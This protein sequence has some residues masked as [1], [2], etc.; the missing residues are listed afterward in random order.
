MSEVN[1]SVFRALA[2]A[3][4]RSIDRP[5]PA[6]PHDPWID[7]IM[8]VSQIALQ[9]VGAMQAGTAEAQR[10]V[11]V[12]GAE[13]QQARREFDAEEAALEAEYLAKRARLVADF[14]PR[15]VG[16]RLNDETRVTADC[17]RAAFA[18]ALTGG[19]L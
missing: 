11:R 12:H 14:G 3:A 13:E 1:S 17:F 10:R 16:A 6:P 7:L 18:P 19:V 4:V 8:N 15:L 9:V 2:E 5:R